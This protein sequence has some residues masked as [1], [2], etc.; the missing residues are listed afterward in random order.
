MF[1]VSLADETQSTRVGSDD[2]TR[3]AGSDLCGLYRLLRST[4][5]AVVSQK[6]SA[7]VAVSY[8]INCLLRASSNS[9][10]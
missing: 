8:A 5:S 2:P 3:N 1:C 4:K 7:A 9:R 10:K 6:P